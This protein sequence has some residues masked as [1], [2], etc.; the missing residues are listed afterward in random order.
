[1][2]CQYWENHTLL[3]TYDWHNTYYQ[4]PSGKSPQAPIFFSC[5]SC[6]SL[7]KP[8]RSSWAKVSTTS[9]WP[10]RRRG[11]EPRVSTRAAW[12]FPWKDGENL[13]K[14]PGKLQKK[15]ETWGN[16]QENCRNKSDFYTM[17]NKE[18]H[19]GKPRGEKGWFCKVTWGEMVVLRLYHGNISGKHQ[20]CRV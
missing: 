9:S 10:L 16:D 14:W 1:M 6:L 17:E 12:M 18:K 8:S 7:G 5:F 2:S 19:A 11:L 13:G 3:L 20:R 4:D 15:W